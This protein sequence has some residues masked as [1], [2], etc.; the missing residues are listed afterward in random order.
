MDLKEAMVV[1][2]R[3]RQLCCP[4]RTC[5]G[6]EV[7]LFCSN[8]SCQYHCIGGRDQLTWPW[9][10]GYGWTKW[11][12]LPEHPASWSVPKEVE[13]QVLQKRFFKKI[14][15]TFEFLAATWHSFAHCTYVF[16]KWTQPGT[17][18]SS[19]QCIGDLPMCSLGQAG[20]RKQNPTTSIRW[21]EA[22]WEKSNMCGLEKL[23]L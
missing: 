11:L 23:Q 6:H 7:H 2:L 17:T 13:I 9:H 21:S 18:A 20:W 14:C 4:I 12:V 8:T 10:V 3:W 22:T 5:W 19:Q 15:I 1:Q 16:W